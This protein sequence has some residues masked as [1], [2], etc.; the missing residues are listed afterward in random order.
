MYSL[1]GRP[2]TPLL[3]P[4]KS[5]RLCTYHNTAMLD[6]FLNSVISIHPEVD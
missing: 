4:I 6:Y 5:R 3:S 2:L 1:V